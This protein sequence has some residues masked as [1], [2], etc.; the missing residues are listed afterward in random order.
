MNLRIFVALVF[1][2]QGCATLHN[3]RHQEISVVSDPAGAD[4]EVRCGK[5]QP[6][7]VTPATVRLPRGAEPCS[8]ILTRPGFHSETVVFDSV[9]SVWV[10]GNFAGPIAGG[11]I[12]ATRHSD[13]AFVDFLFG[14]LLGGAGFGIDA[15]T[16]AMWELEPAKVERKL[17][18]K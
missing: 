5:M 9:P 14:V 8:L 13:Q 10:W 4:V 6:A 2:T 17:V 11:A 12:G 3:G 18:P 1:F 15:L 16:D 7:A